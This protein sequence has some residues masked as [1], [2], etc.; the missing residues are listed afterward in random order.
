M[1]RYI[2][3]LMTIIMI[4]FFQACAVK[5]PTPIQI[6]RSDPLIGK[7]FSAKTAQ[8]IDF[9]NL[10]DIIADYDVI[11]LSEKHDNP[12]QHIAQEQIIESLTK[13]L[14]ATNKKPAI[15]FEFFAMDNTP[16]LLNFIDAGKI[17]HSKKIED[18]IEKDLRMKLGWRKQ[19]DVMWNYYYHLLKLAQKENLVVAGIDIAN[20]IKKR[21]TKKGI[22]GITPLEQKQIFSTQLDDRNYKSYMID[23]FK[24][25]HC[26]MGLGKIEK[27]LYDTWVIRNDKMALS[28]SQMVENTTGP[29]IV[30][31]GGGHTEYNLG[32]ID[33]IH[34][35][36]ADIRQINIGLTE[37]TKRPTELDQYL[38]PLDLEGYP[39]VPRADYLWFFQRTSYDDP[40]EKFKA[41]MKKKKNQQ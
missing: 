34:S 6:K 13:K 12:D 21:I 26:G 35:I 19:S 9:D 5:E 31:V 14:A 41:R 37:I 33:R 38:T 30:I 17:K 22:K 8:P 29:V 3:L 20:T 16:D 25:V 18:I 40:C 32:I 28:I 24:A 39:S 36:D 27:R 4:P 10:I 15:G 11:Y 23:I 7:I 1:N 2:L